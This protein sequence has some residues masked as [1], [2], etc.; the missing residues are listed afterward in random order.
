MNKITRILMIA[1]VLVAIST[2]ATLDQYLKMVTG[3]DAVQAGPNKCP[4]GQES[5]EGC[6]W[7]QHRVTDKC[8]WLPKQAIADP[9]EVITP[10]G[11]CPEPTLVYT[12]IPTATSTLCPTSTATLAPAPTVI[13]VKPSPTEDSTPTVPVI[14]ITPPHGV[15]MDPI[16]TSTLPAPVILSTPV[17]DACR[18]EQQK[19]DAMSTLAAIEATR[20]AKELKP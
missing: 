2:L 7:V 4:P 3:I 19:A 20:L 10:D 8:M 1:F 13:I 12:P 17:C 18:I 6:K 15:K 16:N 9:W 5:K 11:V 14:P